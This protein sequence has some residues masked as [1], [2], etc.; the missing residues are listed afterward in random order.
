MKWRGQPCP[1]SRSIIQAHAPKGHEAQG[2]ILQDLGRGGCL[3]L[4]SSLE[5]RVFARQSA[6]ASALLEMTLLRD[7]D[8]ITDLIMRP[9]VCGRGAR[10]GRGSLLWHC[11]CLSLSVSRPHSAQPGGLAAA[12]GAR[13]CAALPPATRA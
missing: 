10:G 5:A 4:L 6:T 12:A 7:H 1:Q 8:D 11:L 9:G 13:C 2:Q 3:R